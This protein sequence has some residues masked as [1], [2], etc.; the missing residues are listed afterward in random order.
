MWAF[1]MR[2]YHLNRSSFDRIDCY[3]VP[4]CLKHFPRSSGRGRFFQGGGAQANAENKSATVKRPETIPSEY[5]KVKGTAVEISKSYP[6]TDGALIDLQTGIFVVTNVWQHYSQQT[7]SHTYM[8]K[9]RST[10]VRSHQEQLKD[11]T[12]RLALRGAHRPIARL[13]QNKK[14][15][16]QR[17]GERET[18]SIENLHDL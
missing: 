9:I 6:L 10:F 16:A 11:G 3:V 17:S 18:P 4:K 12:Q 8:Y 1:G 15:A 7:D 13:T 14:A 5:L 2:P